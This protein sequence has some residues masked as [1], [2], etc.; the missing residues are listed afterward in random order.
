M[1][2]EKR[3]IFGYALL[4]STIYDFGAGY[5]ERIAPGA[6][7]KADLTDV[8]MLLNHDPGKLLARSKSGTLTLKIDSKGLFFR[9][10]LPQSEL[11]NET[12]EMI[13]RGDLSGCSWGF[14]V[15]K[16]GDTWT[17]TATGEMRTITAVK[18]VF[19]TSACTYPANPETCVFLE[20]GSAD[21]TASKSGEAR[22]MEAELMA[23]ELRVIESRIKYQNQ[24]HHEQQQADRTASRKRNAPTVAEMNAELA[25]WE[26]KIYSR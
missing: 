24:R 21:A 13:G 3:Y 25:A 26:R 12:A 17:T 2:N 19:D 5:W 20:K 11:G 22:Q 23:A 1:K 15:A 9:A 10:L 6:L 4:W 16:G 7:D 8:R 18:R 14:S